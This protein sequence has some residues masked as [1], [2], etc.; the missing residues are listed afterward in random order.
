M[1]R[2]GP[3][4][5]TEYDYS[6]KSMLGI[7]DTPY[8]GYVKAYT[9]YDQST[10]ILGGPRQTE[11]RPDAER[12]WINWRHQQDLDN[13]Q[14]QGQFTYESDPRFYEQYY[15]YLFDTGPNQETFA[16]LKWQDGIVAAT[17]LVEPNVNRYWVNEAQWLPRLDG[18]LIGQS[19]WDRL[20]YN[21][22]GSAGYAD[23]E[24]P[25]VFPFAVQPTDVPTQ[26]GRFDVMQELAAPF[27][28]GALKVVPYAK[29]DLAYY[30]N[31]LPGDRRGRVYGGIGTQATLPLSR[32]YPDVSSE[33]FN[34]DGIYHK[35]VFGANYY[36]AWTDTHHTL[37][38]QLDQLND[39]AT[40]QSFMD[41]RPLQQTFVPG[42][43][44]YAL[45]TSNLFDPQLY[46]IR[47]LV[48]TSADSL[49]NIQVIQTDIRQRFQT[50][51]GYPGMEH[52]VDWLTFDL[53]ASFFPAPKT[54]NFGSS[55]SFIEYNSTWAAGDRTGLVSSG[56]FD[57]F[58]AGA[59]YWTL[60]AYLDRPDRTHFYLGYRQF[61]PVRSKA[62][63]AAVIY[64][65]S[66]KYAITA[67]SVYD[68][69]I[70]SAIS[71]SLVLTRM[72]TDLQISLGVTYNALVNN[73]GVTFQVVPN[74]S[75]YRPGGYSPGIGM[76]GGR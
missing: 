52:T 48:D 35:I 25:K 11:F 33:L 23:L 37:L 5:G 21:A 13:L 34:V 28:L 76:A 17:A 61:D 69:G 6:G 32:L 1:G 49:D 60:G 59:R 72:G 9:I 10:D 31:D 50:Q 4:L 29:L 40:D 64:V 58:G 56:W 71:N 68:F 46:A 44:G 70:N 74:L 62:V 39:D 22:W 26:T 55:V 65:F 18:W 2:R 42:P 24:T 8:S 38:P 47:R 27:A 20:T 41:M 30:T 16:Y 57:P 14:F 3:A 36:N 19:F 66:P 7:T 45:A 54:N 63:T 73:F 75:A 67:S 43:H 53:S 15:K 51:R 12:G